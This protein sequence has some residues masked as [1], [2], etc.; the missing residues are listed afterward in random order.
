[1]ELAKNIRQKIGNTILR[2]KLEK[3]RRKVCY[4]N[5]DSVKKIGIVWDASEV[6]DFSSLS[7][8]CQKMSERNIEVKIL[9]YYP[10]KNLPDQYTAI[11]Y[12]S[13]M[14]REEMNFFY[15]PLSSESDSFIKNRFDILLDINFK[16]LLPL[17]YISSLSEA[18]LKVGLFED[19]KN[20]TVFDLMIDMKKP[21][22]LE[23]YL[24]QTVH[25]LEMI[26]SGQTEKIH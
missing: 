1:M 16:C 21:V 20:G 26:H 17:K 9:G 23:E 19:E 8:F 11:R 4:T 14:R 10:G 3:T 22:N 15:L 18:A 12:L 6:G 2:K 13:C 25:Y 7:R 5:I 24:G